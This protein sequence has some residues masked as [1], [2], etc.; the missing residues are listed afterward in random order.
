MSQPSPQYD[1]TET[2]I[3]RLAVQCRGVVVRRFQHS[4]NARVA[5][6]QTQ[7]GTRQIK[8]NLL[9]PKCRAQGYTVT[10]QK[11]R[12]KTTIHMLIPLPKVCQIQLLTFNAKVCQ[13]NAINLHTFDTIPIQHNLIWNWK[14]NRQS[15][16]TMYTCIWTIFLGFIAKGTLFAAVLNLIDSIISRKHIF[17]VWQS[18]NQHR[19][20]VDKIPYKIIIS[21]K[22]FS[23]Q[24]WLSKELIPI[25]HLL[26]QIF[27]PCQIDHHDSP[28]F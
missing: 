27:M 4:N 14:Y 25:K 28:T 2:G 11:I 20:E 22:Y 18:F 26:L 21:C 8:T 7:D 17:E 16:N 3:A 15:S 10:I 19:V 12:P 13:G 5:S 23:H 24:K 9:L 1:M 6:T